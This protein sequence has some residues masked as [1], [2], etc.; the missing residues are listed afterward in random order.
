[1]ARLRQVLRGLWEYLREVCGENDY[2]RYRAAVLSSGGQP[3]TPECF[4]LWK[5][6]HK[7]SHPNRCC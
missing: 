6:H 1:M 7:F 4:Y 2:A 3:L 5:Q